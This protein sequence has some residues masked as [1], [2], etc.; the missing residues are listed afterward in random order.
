MTTKSKLLVAL[1]IALLA[2]SIGPIQLVGGC[3]PATTTNPC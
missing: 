2:T 3:Q 1:F